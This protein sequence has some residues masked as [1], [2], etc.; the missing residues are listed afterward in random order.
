MVETY[1][2]EDISNTVVGIK[3]ISLTM[4]IKASVMTTP[5]T[6]A[7]KRNPGKQHHHGK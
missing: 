1:A 6:P 4:I 3:I 2:D 7:T 5:D